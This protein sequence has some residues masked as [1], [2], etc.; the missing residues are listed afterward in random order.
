MI[1]NYIFVAISVILFLII[2]LSNLLPNLKLLFNPIFEKTT[3]YGFISAGFIFIEFLVWRLFQIRNL[4]VKSKR[5]GIKRLLEGYWK[6]SKDVLIFVGF[7]KVSLFEV[8]IGILIGLLCGMTTVFSMS[9]FENL[10]I[11]VITFGTFL[12]MLVSMPIEMA[13]VYLIPIFEELVFRG[14]FLSRFLHIFKN[15]RTVVIGLIVSS[16]V[17]GYSHLEYP[18]YKV[19]VGFVLGIVYLWKWKKNIVTSMAAHITGNIFLTFVHTLSV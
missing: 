14:F 17:F 15:R 5:K 16:F 11:E 4:I 6:L 12:K 9:Y 8:L 3:Y 7:R 10:S 2:P 1:Q 18:I 19:F 13:G